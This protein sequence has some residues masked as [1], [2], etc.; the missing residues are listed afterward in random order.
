MNVEDAVLSKEMKEKG[1]ETKEQTT[2]VIRKRRHEVLARPQGKIRNF[3][4]GNP[5]SLTSLL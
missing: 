5:S 4:T 1:R 3:Q 2:T